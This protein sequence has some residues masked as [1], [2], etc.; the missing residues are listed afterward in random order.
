MIKI[1]FGANGAN[2]AVEAEVAARI[3]EGGEWARDV[4][5]DLGRCCSGLVVEK[6][7]GL[8]FLRGRHWAANLLLD[9]P[10][11][12]FELRGSRAGCQHHFAQ[13]PRRLAHAFL[14]VI[15]PPIALSIGH[16]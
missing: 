13:P 14:S 1:L 15:R 11:R 16:R 3:R 6:E 9:K 10:S 8:L 7:G 2:A 12:F 4:G 5:L